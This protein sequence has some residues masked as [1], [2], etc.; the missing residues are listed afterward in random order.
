VTASRPDDR[1]LAAR[2]RL[3]SGIRWLRSP[4]DRAR[5]RIIRDDF[6][7]ARD[8]FRGIADGA[9]AGDPSR[10]AWIVSTF[11]TVW[12][13]KIEGALSLALR[14]RDFRPRAVYTTSDAWTPR[15]HA[16]FGLVDATHIGAAAAPPDAAA[17]ETAVRTQCR[18]VP[19]LLALDYRRVAVGRIALSNYLNANKF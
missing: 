3:S 5:S 17:L 16:L 18:T 8:E 14:T 7:R 13:A 9:P 4:E 10:R 11:Q 6:A 19:E 15:Y 2:R 1:W 12:A